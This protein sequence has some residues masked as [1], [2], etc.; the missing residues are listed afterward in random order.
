[1]PRRS[2]L[3]PLQ[4]QNAVTWLVARNELSRAVEVTELAP[5]FHLRKILNA[6]RETRIAAGGTADPI[7]AACGFF[8]C[9]RLGVRLCIGIEVRAPEV[10][11]LT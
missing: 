8:L 11:H 10:S 9:S 6:A 1:M 7:G 3:D 4:P 2:R 5:N